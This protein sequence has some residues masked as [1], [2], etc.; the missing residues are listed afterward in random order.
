MGFTYVI[1]MLPKLPDR[2]VHDTRIPLE[3]EVMHSRTPVYV[4]RGELGSFNAMQPLHGLCDE[5][6]SQSGSPMYS[7]TMMPMLK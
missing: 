7:V 1:D 3:K 2:L 4:A 6:W 5:L